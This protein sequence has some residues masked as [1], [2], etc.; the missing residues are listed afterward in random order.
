MKKFLANTIVLVSEIVM[1]VLAIIWYLKDSS[2]EALI[3]CIALGT[4]IVVSLF[5][6]TND[7]SVTINT[8]NWDDFTQKVTSKERKRI[9]E[10]ENQ[11]ADK[12]KL[13]GVSETLFDK[14]RLELS[15]EINQLKK[16]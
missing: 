4:S 14:Q 3:A 11:L 7:T 2:I 1:L 13:L 6:K 16:E 5:F 10:L 8:I 15:A 12:Q 9:K